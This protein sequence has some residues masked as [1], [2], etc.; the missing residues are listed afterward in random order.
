MRDK[1]KNL[2]FPPDFVKSATKA[3]YC[4]Y[5]LIGERQDLRHYGSWK[6][7]LGIMLDIED[8]GYNAAKKNPAGTYCKKCSNIRKR[9]FVSME[10]PKSQDQ[11]WKCP[12]CQGTEQLHTYFS[13][14]HLRNI[15]NKILEKVTDMVEYLPMFEMVKGM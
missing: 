4:H 6:G 5:S 1:S 10:P 2:P 15:R 8:H 9:H 12:Q 7:M 14:K 3:I 11:G 13:T